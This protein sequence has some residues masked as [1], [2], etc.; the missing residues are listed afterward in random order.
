MNG[1]PQEQE[2]WRSAIL[3][4]LNSIDD[5]E[6][7]SLDENLGGIP[8]PTHVVLQ[9]KRDASENPDWFKAR[10]VTG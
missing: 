1:S 10:V 6:T 5:N 4:E 7:R 2:L 8:L 3:G 9:M